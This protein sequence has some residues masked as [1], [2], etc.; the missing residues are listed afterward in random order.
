MSA[1]CRVCV[2]ASQVSGSDYLRALD[3]NYY[4]L[5]ADRH[6]NSPASYSK[7]YSNSNIDDYADDTK[8]RKVCAHD[9]V[10]LVGREKS[11][12]PFG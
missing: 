5:A 1:V 9:T 3:Y 2:S 10:R 4:Y 7:S 11:L 6:N 12:H 8:R